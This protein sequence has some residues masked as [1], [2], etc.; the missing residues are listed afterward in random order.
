MAA[1]ISSA[2]T[3]Y[4]TQDVLSASV[5]SPAGF[6]LAN[7]YRSDS[8][9]YNFVI[10][11]TGSHADNVYPITLNLELGDAINQQTNSLNI[12]PYT[13]TGVTVSSPANFAVKSFSQ[14][15]STLYVTLYETAAHANNSYSV[16]LTICFSGAR[17]I[18][19]YLT[20]T[21]AVKVT[22]GRWVDA[23]T[24]DPGNSPLYLGSIDVSD[25]TSLTCGGQTHIGTPTTLLGNLQTCFNNV[26]A[27]NGLQD[28]LTAFEPSGSFVYRAMPAATDAQPTPNVVVIRNDL[29]QAPIAQHWI[30][31]VIPSK[32]S[33]APN[34][35]FSVDIRKVHATSDGSLLRTTYEI[36]NEYGINA[37][38]GYVLP[39]SGAASDVK[40]LAATQD[41]N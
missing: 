21:V 34:Y 2:L 3:N 28:Y 39:V 19:S 30:E 29:Y 36:Q 18:L 10:S 22:N 32:L 23:S 4:A 20:A 14:S 5:A 7:Y 1:M 24:A 35:R 11:E 9:H 40:P 17:C 33:Y 8:G 31:Y 37:G 6:T 12:S 26:V 38:G 25:S 16:N 15:G 41:R 13:A 27:L